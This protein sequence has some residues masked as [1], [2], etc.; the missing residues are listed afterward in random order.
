[1]EAAPG[2]RRTEPINFG[3]NTRQKGM[4]QMDIRTICV[5]IVIVVMAVLV[6][7]R[8]A[9][10]KD[11]AQCIGDIYVDWTDPLN[12]EFYMALDKEP[13]KSIKDHDIVYM[14]VNYVGTAKEA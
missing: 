10:N 5:L 12:V 1:M 9:R 3:I 13:D 14:R 11:K 2:A 7:W 4:M 6:T 8:I